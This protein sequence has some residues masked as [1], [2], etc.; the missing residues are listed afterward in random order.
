M[1]EPER[2]Q[3]GKVVLYHKK[4]RER[5]ERWPVDARGMLEHGE[6]VAEPPKG[7]AKSKP[8][9]ESDSNDQQAAA[10]ATEGAEAEAEAPAPVVPGHP[11]E[12]ASRLLEQ[13]DQKVTPEEY[14]KRWPNAKTD[15]A[16][17]AAEIVALNKKA[18]KSGAKVDSEGSPAAPVQL[19]EAGRTR[20]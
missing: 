9:S 2:T 7:K 12:R 17:L 15:V 3:Y 18:A 14:V 20:G 16:K 1:P 5:I 10:G 6:Y 19:P 4:T 8:A 13:W 11:A